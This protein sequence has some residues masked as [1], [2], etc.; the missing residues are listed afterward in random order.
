MNLFVA[1]TARR[2]GVALRLLHAAS[3]HAKAAGGIR[4]SLETARDNLGAQALYRHAG[5][6]A[7]ETQWF[8][9]PLTS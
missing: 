2:R 6:S 4:V 5:W 7:D 3:E 8:H 9:L 1:E